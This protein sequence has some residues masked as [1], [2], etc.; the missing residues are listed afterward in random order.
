MAFLW[1]KYWVAEQAFTCTID[2]GNVVAGKFRWLSNSPHSK[3]VLGSRL[4]VPSCDCIHR[5]GLTHSITD[6]S[7]WCCWRRWIPCERERF[8]RWVDECAWA[9]NLWRWHNQHF[10]VVEYMI[11]ARKTFEISQLGYC[12]T[13]KAL[14]S[15]LHLAV[16]CSFKVILSNLWLHFT[17]CLANIFHLIVNVHCVSGNTSPFYFL[18]VSQMWRGF[19]NFCQK[20]MPQGIL[21]GQIWT[22]HHNSFYMFIHYLV[23]TTFTAYSIAL[24]MKY[25]HKSPIVSCHIIRLLS[26]NIMPIQ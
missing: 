9:W 10:T 11:L 4:K 21:N 8:F 2:T 19:A 26:H 12:D 20:K 25:P 16:R 1:E 5:T 15:F 23:K 18:Y 13:R 6:Q 17:N 3:R 7:I 22:A 24:N 14:H